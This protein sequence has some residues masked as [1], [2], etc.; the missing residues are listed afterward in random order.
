MS[1]LEA[2]HLAG[3]YFLHDIQDALTLWGSQ[4]VKLEESGKLEQSEEVTGGLGS[5]A[6]YFSPAS[7]HWSPTELGN[8]ETPRPPPASGSRELGCLVPPL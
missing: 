8:K 6:S 7:F 2:K 3:K 4:R 5:S 1:Q